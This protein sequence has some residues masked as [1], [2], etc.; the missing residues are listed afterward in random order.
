MTLLNY[1]KQNGELTSGMLITTPLID[2]IEIYGFIS[3]IDH[4]KIFFTRETS[5]NLMTNLNDFIILADKIA[6]KHFYKGLHG[7]NLYQVHPIFKKIKCNNSF[8]ELL[9]ENLYIL[10]L[11]LDDNIKKEDKYNKIPLYYTLLRNRKLAPEYYPLFGERYSIQ[12][13]IKE[14]KLYYPTQPNDILM[15]KKIYY[16]DSQVS[17]I[18]KDFL[19]IGRFINSVTGELNHKLFL[20]EEVSILSD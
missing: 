7:E 10:Q 9:F 13:V 20:P 15:Y 2:K 6:F 18:G 16:S 12:T 8:E 11:E 4:Q 14:N 17:A 1:F 5:L 19:I 3:Y